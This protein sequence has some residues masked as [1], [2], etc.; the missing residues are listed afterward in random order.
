MV[1]AGMPR[2]RLLCPG[3]CRE[4]GHVLQKTNGKN[5]LCGSAPTCRPYG[6]R[7]VR[8][9]GRRWM[10]RL[11]DWV[12]AFMAALACVTFIF[13]CL[14]R[15][16]QVSGAS[17]RPTLSEGD[18]LLIWELGYHPQHGDIV[19]IDRSHKG[20]L[21]IIK[22]VIGL[23]GDVIDIDLARG[24]VLRNHEPIAEPYTQGPTY[25]SWDVDFPVTV[26]D[27]ALFVL[28]D[29]RSHSLD[30]RSSE[31]GMVDEQRLMRRAVFRLTPFYTAGW[32]E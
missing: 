21:P 31:I 2:R 3:G 10:Q 6:R 13:L 32:I 18:R 26:P 23:P 8:P 28:G 1:D 11:Y 24:M 12:G 14:A 7:P 17:M 29:N 5:L 16:A 30:S 27:G 19:V 15:T 22:R 4:G 20:E 25:L 9:A